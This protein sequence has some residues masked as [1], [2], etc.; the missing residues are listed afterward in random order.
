[1]ITKKFG[2]LGDTAADER[3]EK[4]PERALLELGNLLLE[5]WNLEPSNHG[6]QGPGIPLTAYKTSIPVRD[7][8]WSNSTS[9]SPDMNSWRIIAE[10]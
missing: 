6:P 7:C 8:P 9:P 5:I 4:N 10:W 3:P 2:L 1:L